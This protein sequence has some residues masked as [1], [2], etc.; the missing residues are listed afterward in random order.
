MNEKPLFSLTSI[1]PRAGLLDQVIAVIQ[2]K[3]YASRMWR[4]R[5]SVSVGTVSALALI[6]VGISLVNAF[7]VSH[8]GSYLSLVFSDTGMALSYW[9]EIAVS[10]LE[11]VPA[12][13]L[14]MTLALTGV[15]LWSMRIAI[16][17]LFTRSFISHA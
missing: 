10:L 17:S 1:S 6:P 13:A 16:Q 2:N 14:T 9:K 8:F 4:I 5:V 15:L 3:Q 12:V 7:A 11:S